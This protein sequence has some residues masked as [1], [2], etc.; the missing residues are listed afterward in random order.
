MSV[1]GGGLALVASAASTHTLKKQ[2]DGGSYNAQKQPVRSTFAHSSLQVSPQAIRN[3]TQV[4]K[5]SV[6]CAVLSPFSF[7]F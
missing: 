3:R 5:M 2:S 7:F 4:L 6:S 1:L